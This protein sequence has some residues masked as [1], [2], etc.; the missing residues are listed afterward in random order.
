MMRKMR[1]QNF[2]AIRLV[3]DIRLRRE[4][5]GGLVYDT[6]N[7]NILEVDRSAFQFL[8]LIKDR[9]LDLND[10]IAFLVQ[11]NIIK[12][13]DKSID[14]TLQKLLELKIIEKNND[15]SSSPIS[16]AQDPIKI[17]HES[18][19]SAPETVHWAV[20]YRCQESCPDCYARRFSFIKDELDT[21]HALKL[22]DK[23]AHWDVFQ[24][25][26][27][28]GE[29]FIREDLP[30][31]VQYA[32][33]RGLSVHI[34]TAKLDIP[35][36][37]L[38]SLC[39]SIKNLQLG[40][41]PDALL[42]THSTKSIQQIQNLFTTTQRLGVTPGANIFLTKSAIEQLENLIKILIGIGFNRLILL[43]YKPPQSVKRW[44]VEN[45][46]IEQ[47]RGLPEKINKIV[48]ENP[49]LNIRVDCALSFV[50]RH[51]PKELATKL[52]IKGCVA[53]DRILALAPDGSAYPCSQLV[54]PTFLAGNLVESEAELLWNQSR[55]L[56]KY[57]S[58]RTKKAFTHSWCGFCQAKD[59][60]GGCRVFASDGLGGDPGCPEPLL[61]PLTQLGNI[62]RSLD[63]TEY[64]KNHHTIS[65]KE[66]MD[67]YRVGQKK[68]I[69]ELNV[70]PHTVST[71]GKSIR[72][73][74]DACQH[75]E[76]NIVLE[77]QRIIGFTK[78]R[79]PYVPYEQVSEW[80]ESPAYLKDY[81]EWIRQQINREKKKGEGKNE[82][83]NYT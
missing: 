70:S 45:P 14:E 80:I 10:I 27:G 63:L 38:E 22:I 47:M 19:L 75:I 39:P 83:S 82:D 18:W 71:T 54:H 7:G 36:H 9:A 60:C 46:D 56:R 32:A 4:F 6:R 76:E 29:P 13:F 30:H 64:L 51:L 20:T 16:I 78:A 15:S 67:R 81:P 50:Q 1:P 57:R 44:R 40:I 33:N 37:L 43:R 74:R 48:R 49:S 66:Y 2:T 25:A 53:A 55:I 5:F 26:I 58:F 73:K 21:H 41:Q 3:P 35:A 17:N 69:K 61:P 68:A 12:K 8:H 31:L 42:G 34:T 62:G 52:G 77:V 24:L 72:K 11:N 28:G 65:V 79:V 23:I 59:N